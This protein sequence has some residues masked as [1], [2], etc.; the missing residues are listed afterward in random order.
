[1]STQSLD[2]N[3][4]RVS[5]GLGL[6][7]LRMDDSR[8]QIPN[9]SNTQPKQ[10]SSP[11]GSKSTTPTVTTATLQAKCGIPIVFQPCPTS[12][13]VSSA[14]SPTPGDLRLVGYEEERKARP[15]PRYTYRSPNQRLLKSSE[16]ILIGDG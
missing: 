4:S 8:V 15:Q 16:R 2:I 14:M 12:S 11:A 9:T 7:E 6:E 3:V 5:D 1:M 10:L 13:T